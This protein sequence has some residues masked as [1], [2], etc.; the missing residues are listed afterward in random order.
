MSAQAPARPPELNYGLDDVPKPF[1]K[2]MGLGLQHVLTMFG[3][4]IAVPFILSPYLDFDSGQLAIL[5]SSVFIASA[6][7]TALQVQFGSRLPIV[8]GVSFAFLGPFIGLALA[9]EGELAMRYIAGGSWPAPWSRCS[10]GSAASG[11]C[12]AGTSPRSRSRRSSR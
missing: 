8:Q 1:P 5:I 11:A 12:C 6:V 2:A 10:S 3:A 9:Y 4:T 7:A